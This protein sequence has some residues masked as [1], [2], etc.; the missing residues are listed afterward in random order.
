MQLLNRISIRAKLFTGFGIVIL[1]LAASAGAAFWGFSRLSSS[2]HEVDAVVT[3]K[4]ESA[5][6]MR[7]A[8]GDLHYSQTKYVLQGPSQRANFLGDIATYKKAQLA[9]RA[10]ANDPD[11]LEGLD[12]VQAKFKA[13]MAVDS[14]MWAAVRA[15]RH[16]AA[17]TQ[18]DPSDEAAD[19]LVGATED[20]LAEVKSEQAGA[21]RAFAS[22]RSA[23]EKIM[24][25]VALVALLAAAGIAWALTRR[26]SG[27]LAPLRERLTS[28]R[29]ECLTGL[30][31]GLGAIAAEGDLAVD[32]VPTTNT[33]AV[34]GSDEIAELGRTFNDMLAK[35]QSSIEAYN[36]MRARTAEMANVAA[37]I[38]EG[39]LSTKVE[40]LSDRDQ[41]GRAFLEMQAYLHEAAE[42]AAAVSQGDVSRAVQVRSE[43]DV[44]G[45]A[46]AD[47][48][49]Y[50]R[51]M[52]SAAERIAARDLSL[53]IE[54]RS[55]QDALGIA[56]RG[57]TENVSGVLFDVATAT[58][59]LTDAA[60]QLTTSSGEAGRAVAEIANA[61]GD[62]ATGA[63]RSHTGGL[64]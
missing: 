2:E 63:D 59:R 62:V 30:E 29:D 54:P 14:R 57:M 52:V 22:S 42:A 51:E 18:V 5:A 20:Y 41:F 64:H 32:V 27:G 28:L 3:P 35:V 26:L 8:I 37:E 34:D 36:A 33:V 24:G 56:M 11:D 1:L 15:G 61:V 53:E 23:S 31:G 45:S 6:D 10:A 49:E 58:S 43:A 4:V 50:L 16:R 17:V 55:A 40:V 44:L 46:F 47:M 19:A 9:A 25:G 7:S 38:S 60:H 21:V 39:D 48:Q 12:A 13:F